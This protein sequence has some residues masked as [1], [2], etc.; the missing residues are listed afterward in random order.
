[1]KIISSFKKK[2]N[3]ISKKSDIYDI[4]KPLFLVG[5]L[6]GLSPYSEITQKEKKF[7][8][9]TFK[10]SMAVILYVVIYTTATFYV[11]YNNF[12]FILSLKNNGI[13]L[14]FLQQILSTVLSLMEIVFSLIFCKSLTKI[15][16][17]IDYID[18]EFKKLSVWMCD[19]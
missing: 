2:I 3:D 15:F 6:F 5:K 7:Y 1:M 14:Q 9:I 12:I 13:K 8:K 11:I 16:E 4:F 18:F 10:S 17:N 19:G